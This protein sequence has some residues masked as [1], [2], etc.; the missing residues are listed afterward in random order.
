MNFK[1]RISNLIFNYEKEWVLKKELCVRTYVFHM[2]GT[3]VTILCNWLN[4]WQNALYLYFG[5]SRMCL[6]LQETRFQETSS[7]VKA[8]QVCLRMKCESAAH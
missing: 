6:M 2:L 8:M 7:S 1:E 3:Y 5:R 4:L